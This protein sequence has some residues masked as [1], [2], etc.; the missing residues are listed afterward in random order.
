MSERY[1]LCNDRFVFEVERGVLVGASAAEDAER[2]PYLNR[3]EGYGSLYLTWEE[4][5]ALRQ[6]IPFAADAFADA[7]P[8]KEE[9][10]V[11]YRGGIR[12]DTLEVTVR[13]M[14]GEDAAEHEIRVKNI[15]DKTVGLLDFGIR[16]SC[17]SDFERGSVD[18]QILG[19]HFVAGSGSHSTLYRCDGKGKLLAVLPVGESKWIHF[20]KAAGNEY[21]DEEKKGRILLYSLN[22]QIG[23]VREREGS[24]LRLPPESRRLAPGEDY[25]YTGRIFLAEDYED[26]RD[27]LV[28]SGQAVAESVPGYTVPQDQPCLLALRCACASLRVESADCGIEELGENRGYRLYRL[29]FSRLGECT[30]RILADGR[31]TQLYYFVTESVRTLLEKRAAFIA[32]RQIRDTEKWYD[33]LFAE[34]NNETG[35]CL[36]PDNYDRIRGWRI[37]EVSCDDPGLSKPAYLSSFQTV[38]PVQEQ[39]D[40][41]EYYVERFVWGGLQQTEEEPFPY[42][43]Y[44][45]PDWHVLRGSADIGVRGKSHLWRIYDYPH[46]ALL[47]YNLYQTAAF[48]EHV[49]TKLDARTY[50]LRAYGTARAMFTVPLELEGWSAYET[51]LYNE[52]VIPKIIEALR[53]E[54]FDTQAYILESHW[55][56]KVL[57]FAGE[58]TDVFGSEYAFDTT[59]FESTHVLAADALRLAR[60]HEKK[61]Q[62]DERIVPERAAEFMERQTACNIACRGVLEPAY[63]WYGSDYRGD[64]L[65]YT[66]SYMTQ[67]GGCSLLDY[68]CYYAK[69]PFALLRLASGSLLGS[70]ALMNT[71]NKDSGYGYWY[72]GEE[73]DGCACGGFEPLSSGETWLGQPHHGGAWYY[74]CEIDL[75]FCGGLRGA[76]SVVAEDPVFG[77]ICYGG[78]MTERS[79]GL[80]V[81]SRDGVGRSFHY[82]GES[83]RIHAECIHGAWT[84][85]GIVLQSDGGGF[86]L[87]AESGP[88]KPESLS[89]RVMAEGFGDFLLARP[90]ETFGDCSSPMDEERG[91]NRCQAE[92]ILRDGI[93]S[94]IRIP[95]GKGRLVFVRRQ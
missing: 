93:W 21:K 38:R 94:H 85:D 68:A 74:S 6:W 28:R 49:S 29:A 53:T 46:V 34:Y 73:K 8:E 27:R 11:C 90:E 62:H 80:Y 12:N 45:I 43:I 1:C 84:E 51:G 81:S 24:V 76:A 56:R 82:I 42:G 70:Y 44:G 3:E 52:L 30:V 18:R 79:E 61:L 50:L 64:N 41:L 83:G 59:G 13:Y 54:G 4:G 25:I 9:Q 86:V 77:R 55:R 19:H 47:Y 32:K 72:P 2:T 16:L 35:I 33:G 88:W 69:E 57:Y 10:C 31:C 65:H 5:G 40:A 22:G 92:E 75:G 66:L 89:V 20:E 60:G 17:H 91:M 15:S 7:P 48:A 26:C 23:S 87:E 63:F 95:S 37:Y 58:P 14:L 67:M 71:G 36:S 78:V 39:V